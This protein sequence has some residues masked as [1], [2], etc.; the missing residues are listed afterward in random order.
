MK[1]LLCVLIIC[2]LVVTLIGCDKKDN[3]SELNSNI[4]SSE[5]NSEKPDCLHK[6]AQIVPNNISNE[7][8]C[9]LS[10][11]YLKWCPDCNAKIQ[12]PAEAL[13]H[14]G[15]TATCS[16]KAICSRCNNSYGEINKDN[17]S[18]IDTSNNSGYKAATCTQE[19]YTGD[20]AYCLACKTSISEG[21]TITALGHTGGTATCDKKAICSRCNKEYGDYNSSN[22]S[23]STTIK[24]TIS[25]TCSQNGY[26]GNVVCTKCNGVLTVGEEI[27]K[28]GHTGGTATCD[29]KAICNRCN[30]EYGNYNATNHSGGTVIKNAITPTCSK[31]GYTGDTYCKGCNTIIKQGDSIKKSEHSITEEYIQSSDSI[32]VFCSKCSYVKSNDK[33]KPIVVSIRTVVNFGAYFYA[34]ATGGYGR[35][36]YKYELYN[37]SNTLIDT[38][39][40]KNDD[41]WYGLYE[42]KLKENESL[43]LIIKDTTGHQ[44]EKLYTIKELV[45]EDYFVNRALDILNRMTLMSKQSTIE[46]AMNWCSSSSVE[47]ALK[48]CTT[49]WNQNAINYADD[50]INTYLHSGFY[51]VCKAE[52]TKHMQNSKFTDAEISYMY[53]N[54]SIDWNNQAV[55]RVE[56][57]KSQGNYKNYTKSG[58]ISLLEHFGF[59]HDQ[60]FSGL[61]SRDLTKDS[62]AFSSSSRFT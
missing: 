27:T 13:G 1:K 32:K 26:T 19:G 2:F 5:N 28:L 33:V 52:L 58:W 45:G 61:S 40:F 60:A 25:P 59:T 6:K 50:K 7:P 34:S 30:K 12:E 36:S 62:A 39:D 11:F 24:N 16:A 47:K 15:G 43:K 41:T 54:Y 57:E 17:H 42:N 46:L 14:T 23:G 56:E 9:V 4:S 10:G 18:N 21:K 53:N 44:S 49:N 29:K 20:N 38:R 55:K 37:E 8:T 48:Q 35:Y 31:E 3:D 22:H 51:G